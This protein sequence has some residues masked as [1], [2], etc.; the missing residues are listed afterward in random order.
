VCILRGIVGWLT[1]FSVGKTLPFG[2]CHLRGFEVTVS[3]LVSHLDW[4]L[5]LF[6]VHTCKQLYWFLAEGEV[7]LTSFCLSW[8]KP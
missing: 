1:N 4:V 6:T 8:K 7:G 5:E 2:R 3:G